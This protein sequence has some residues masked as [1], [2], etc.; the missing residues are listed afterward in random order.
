MRIIILIG[1]LFFINLPA[2]ADGLSGAMKAAEMGMRAQSY[3]LK[4]ISENIA[5]S[6]VTGNTA[7]EN[8]YRRKTISFRTKKDEK[9]GANIVVVDKIS[10]DMSDFHLRYE[11]YHPAADENGYVKYP[12]VELILESADAKEAQRTFEANLN[13]FNI[14]KSNREII[15]NALK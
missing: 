14:S 13:S 1:Y 15:I 2:K 10:E 5:N 9:T 8:P 7:Q 6:N 3:R 4:I 12:N 11:P